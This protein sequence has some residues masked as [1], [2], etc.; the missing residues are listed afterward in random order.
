M[1]K[2]YTNPTWM[3][4]IMID[5]KGDVAGQVN[6]LSVFQIG[7]FMF[8]RPSRITAETYMGKQGVVNIEREAKLS[9]KTHD[10]GVLILSGI[11]D[12]LSLKT[13]R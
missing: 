3:I 13:T 2:K 11:W 12:E 4:P 1:K 7:D 10:K 5:V 6:A 9:G 8:G